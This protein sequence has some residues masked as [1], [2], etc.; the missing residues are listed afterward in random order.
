[1]ILLMQHSHT[2]S[3]TR[4]TPNSLNHTVQMRKRPN[5]FSYISMK[6]FGF[7]FFCEFSE[8]KFPNQVPVFGVEYKLC[9][10]LM[11]LQVQE[12]YFYRERERSTAKES[13]MKYKERV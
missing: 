4:R 11:T 7:C 13:N 3:L 1:M 8:P 2:H 9:D 6:L 10:V 5:K 12:S